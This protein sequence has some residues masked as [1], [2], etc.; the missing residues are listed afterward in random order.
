[1]RIVKV[2]E[3][4]AAVL[5]FAQQRVLYLDLV[6]LSA[7]SFGAPIARVSLGVWHLQLEASL[8]HYIVY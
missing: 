4:C 3:G 1:M 8:Q 6:V 5:S 2:H 7:L